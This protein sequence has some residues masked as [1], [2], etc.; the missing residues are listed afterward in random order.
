VAV[1]RLPLQPLRGTPCSH[2]AVADDQSCRVTR[3]GRQPA[4]VARAAHI[5][6]C[7]HVDGVDRAILLHDPP[8]LV[9]RLLIREAAMKG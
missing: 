2:S 9:H 3:S 7:L 5:F 4:M 6:T 1:P 8:H